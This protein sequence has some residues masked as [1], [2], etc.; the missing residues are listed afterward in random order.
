MLVDFLLHALKK[1]SLSVLVVSL[2]AFSLLNTPD[3][4]DHW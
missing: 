3:T 1:T 2:F 4:E